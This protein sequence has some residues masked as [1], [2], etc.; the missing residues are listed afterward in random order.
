MTAEPR[1]LNF[2]LSLLVLAAAITPIR[3]DEPL[4]IS[5][6][7]TWGYASGTGK[8][9]GAFTV[10]A[11][12]PDELSRVVFFIDDQ[13]LGDVDQAPFELR[14]ST[15]DYPLGEHQI[16]AVGHAESGFEYPSNIILADFVS[17]DEGWQ[18]AFTFLLPIVVIII[19]AAGLALLVPMIFARGRKE[20]LPPGAPRAYGAYG[21]AICPKCAR[22]FSRHIYGLNLGLHKYDRCP[23]CGKWSLVRRASKEA[24]QAAEAAEISAAEQGRF[25]PEQ[26]AEVLMRQDIEDS[27]FEDL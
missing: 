26:S 6:Q 25:T 7:R 10:R 1:M 24:L 15:D 27:R 4:K 2:I 12:G 18:A 19:V 20:E 14:F 17:A 3:E 8:I 5:L 13:V 22:P 21:G 23:Y 16:R 9:Q 11:A